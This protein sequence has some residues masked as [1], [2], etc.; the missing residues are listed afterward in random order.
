MRGRYHLRM[1]PHDERFFLEFTSLPTCAGREGR[2]VR[3]IENWVSEREDLELERDAS[4]NLTVGFK[5]ER[6]GSPVYFTAH[7]DHP[8][9]AVERVIAPN[10]LEL[11]F[12]GGV[13][14]DYFPGTRV[15]VVTEGDV[16]YAGVIT[17]ATEATSESPYKHFLCELDEE[18][19][20]ITTRDIAR[21]LL[22][23]AEITDGI[24]HTHACDD[25]AAAACAMVAMDRIRDERAR[26]EHQADVRLLFT[27]AEEVGFIGALAAVRHG[28]IPA[29][30]K[31]IA[32]EN[33][34]AFSES[35]IGGGPIVRV[36][37]RLTI[38]SPRLT[39]DIARIAEDIAGG[40]ASPKASQKE[41][42][43]PKWKW[44]RKLMAGGAC[45]ATVFCHAGL[46]ATC[47]CLPLGNYHN[48]ANLDEAQAGTLNEYEI[49]REYVSMDDARGMID[50]LAACGSRLA[51]PP[52]SKTSQKLD[53]LWESRR[54]ILDEG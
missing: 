36:G 12:R 27:R 22:P 42:D 2:L 1:T 30:A 29:E 5:G 21:W 8:A 7:L 48:M 9:F 49:A 16:R 10:V 28:T 17:E 53:D 11:A 33:S 46:D 18:A 3:F 19:E 20:G 13:M 51:D 35:P 25:L 34:R 4:G 43:M 52:R 54:G 45:E 31:V 39:D 47:V 32:L 23:E 26:G 44:Q 14:D 38:F 15:E 40:P 50:L 41:S 37:D 6:S 24:L